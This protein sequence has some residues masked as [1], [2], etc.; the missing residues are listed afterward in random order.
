M[1]LYNN[2]DDQ[3][4]AAVEFK[5]YDSNLSTSYVPDINDDQDTTN[6]LKLPCSYKELI[7]FR[8]TLK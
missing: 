3:E 4:T 2:F 7:T 8:F 1:L 5:V 6:Y